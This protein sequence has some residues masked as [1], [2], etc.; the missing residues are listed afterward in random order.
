MM[1]VTGFAYCLSHGDHIRSILAAVMIMIGAVGSA[2]CFILSSVKT[3]VKREAVSEQFATILFR[4]VGV[5]LALLV[6]RWLVDKSFYSI[7]SFVSRSLGG[8]V[9]PLFLLSGLIVIVSYFGFPWESCIYLWNGGKLS[10]VLHVI[11]C[12]N[13]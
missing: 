12:E 4:L 6:S 7:R 8:K 2:S 11:E 1:F 13:I 5:G 9:P 10:F 3:A